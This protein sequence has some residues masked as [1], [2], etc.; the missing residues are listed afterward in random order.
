M[1][2][3]RRRLCGEPAFARGGERCEAGNEAFEADDIVLASE[4]SG[5]TAP[6][7]CWRCH[8]LCTEHPQTNV[9]GHAPHSARQRRRREHTARTGYGSRRTIQRSTRRPHAAASTR[10]IYVVRP[11][12]ASCP[13]SRWC[14]LFRRGADAIGARRRPAAR[15]HASAQVHGEREARGRELAHPPAG[16]LPICLHKPDRLESSAQ[17]EFTTNSLVVSLQWVGAILSPG[18]WPVAGWAK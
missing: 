14:R 4:V 9:R 2:P 1:P 18:K 17:I 11:V 16:H 3:L 7:Q 12:H 15:A 10:T 13:A 6:T 5:S 8:A